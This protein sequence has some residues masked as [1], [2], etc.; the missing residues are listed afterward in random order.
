MVCMRRFSGLNYALRYMKL[1]QDRVIQSQV[2]DA[3]RASGGE[4][5]QR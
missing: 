5:G 2:D 3:Q 4:E 1:E